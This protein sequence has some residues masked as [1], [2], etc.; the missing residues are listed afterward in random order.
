MFSDCTHTQ[1]KSLAGEKT[2]DRLD[3]VTA[4]DKLLHRKLAQKAFM[5]CL[6]TN[7]P[8]DLH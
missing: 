3:L 7:L 4:A 1:D 2:F 6:K 5:N 8:C